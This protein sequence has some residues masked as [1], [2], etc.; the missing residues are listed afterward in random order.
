MCQ[1]HALTESKKRKIQ[2][3]LTKQYTF[4]FGTIR[5]TLK[6]Y[7]K[8]FYKQITFQANEKTCLTCIEIKLLGVRHQII[9]FKGSFFFNCDILFE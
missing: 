3:T 4:S 9:D 1:R 6:I 2:R 7:I 8:H 5:V